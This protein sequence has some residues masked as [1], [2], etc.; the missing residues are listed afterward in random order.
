MRYKMAIKDFIQSM[1][2]ALGNMD[3]S[4]YEPINPF[5][6]HPLFDQEWVER[7]KEVVEKSKNRSLPEL[8]EKIKGNSNLRS[9]LFFLLL[10]L[11][12]AKVEKDERLKIVDFFYQLL[13]IKAKGDLYG[14]KSNIAHTEEEVQE[15]LKKEFTVANS[16]IAKLLGRIY[17]AAYHFANGLYSD[18]YTDYGVENFGPYDL[19]NG[20]ILVIKH[21]EDLKPTKLWPQIKTS[22]KTMTIYCVYKDVKFK[23]D[24][25]SAHTVYEG[26]Q[27]ERLKSYL[28]EVD[29][30][31]VN[32]KE[33]LVKLKEEMERLSINQWE[34]LTSLDKE[35]LKLKVLEQ[36]CYVL[37]DL[38]E[39]LGID[40]KPNP[41]MVTAVGKRELALDTW[42]P[43]KENE[44]EYWFKVMN[45]E[46]EFCG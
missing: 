44:K 13:K 18:F 41:E 25:I 31:V 10:D 14:E 23:C 45:P 35:K 17:S 12:S 19:E 28:V 46:E 38:F 27:I 20:E 30:K 34:K 4:T 33:K 22:C 40:W 37:K 5:L 1:Q 2:A 29:G 9:Q 15:I 42:N 16:E 7:I 3:L 8:A 24:A 21:F 36:R 39:F 6:F 32:E 26:D 11:K 43:E